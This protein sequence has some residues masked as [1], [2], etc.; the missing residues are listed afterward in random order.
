MKNVDNAQNVAQWEF[1]RHVLDNQ[2]EPVDKCRVADLA[3]R[4]AGEDM[5]NS[6]AY[7]EH[8]NA[9]SRDECC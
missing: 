9:D 8:S 1:D 4:G 7:E 6:A 3:R 2:S 5:T